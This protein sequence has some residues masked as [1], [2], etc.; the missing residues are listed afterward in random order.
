MAKRSYDKADK[1]HALKVLELCDG[2]LSAA[3][4]ELEMPRKTLSRWLSESQAGGQSVMADDSPMADGLTQKQARFA[5]EYARSGNATQSARE[6]GYAGDDAT[7]ASVGSENLRKPQIQE[8]IRLRLASAASLTKDEVLGTLAD[9]MRGDMTDMFDDAGRFSLK[10]A[11]A[12]RVT[13]LIKKLKFDDCG[14]VREIEL[15]NQQS[16]SKQLSKIFGLEQK[17]KDNEHDAEAKRRAIL[18]KAADLAQKHGI[19]ADAALDKLLEARPDLRKWL[20]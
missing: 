15:H 9:H 2:N 11:R 20:N 3:A 5:D 10:A 14:M 18:N 17:R 6:A 4:R 12:N 1:I 19:T 13:H 8:R 16:A 7:L